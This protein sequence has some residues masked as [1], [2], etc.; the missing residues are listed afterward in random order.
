MQNAIKFTPIDKSIAIVLDRIN[1]R[2]VLTITD[3]GIGIDESMDLF[4]PFK[5]FG[6]ESGAGLGLFLAKNAADALGANITLKNRTDGKK[7]TVAKIE[8]LNNPHLK[9][10]TKLKTDSRVL[11]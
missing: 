9:N 2:A 10:L 1:D 5:R 3:E 8:L 4:A 7:G 11:F 6:E